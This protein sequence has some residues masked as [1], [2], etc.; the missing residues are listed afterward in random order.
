[1]AKKNSIYLSVGIF[2]LSMV[3]FAL[4]SLQSNAAAEDEMT[5]VKY[6]SPE[7]F[8][9]AQYCAECHSTIYARWRD[10][11]HAHAMDDPIFE[12]SYAMA[13][14]RTGGEAKKDCLRC[15]APTT[16]LTGDLDQRLA[17]TRE[18]VT[19][20]FCHLV[21][22]VDLSDKENPFT[23]Q[24][25]VLQNADDAP[26]H[27]EQIHGQKRSSVLTQA[28]FCAGCHEYTD[29]NGVALME[30]Y[31]E[32][33][34]SE[35]GRQ[36]IT[37]QA[38]HMPRPDGKFRDHRMVIH[39]SATGPGGAPRRET[40]TEKGQGQITIDLAEVNRRGG[41]LSVTVELTN[42]RSGHGIPTGM[43]SRQLVLVC[44]VQILPQGETMVRR[45]VFGKRVVERVSGK[46]FDNDAEL[47]IGPSRLLSDNRILPKE[48]RSETF[49]FMVAPERDAVVRAYV[50]YLYRPAMIQKTEL[51][52]HVDGDE[53]MIPGKGKL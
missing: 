29:G 28:E 38:C 52:I 9:S 32:W 24:P 40:Q 44:E 25:A 15:H 47:L 50:N 34:N 41:L 45:R 1:M 10:S 23:L 14:L 5:D 26:K 48:T 13:Y 35:Y 31:S 42:A 51:I 6:K 7:G 19:C 43:P 3:C 33:K 53:R 2:L 12:A 22:A 39:R 21:S 18:G 49:R 11:M 30:T 4:L 17:I 20:A 16:L 36:G 37:C 27:F 8:P 46:D